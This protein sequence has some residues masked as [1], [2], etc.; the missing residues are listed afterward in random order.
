MRHNSFTVS[1]RRAPLKFS[2][3]RPMPK[4]AAIDPCETHGWWTMAGG[5]DCCLPGSYQG[6]PRAQ[7]H[8]DR[9]NDRGH[10]RRR[11]RRALPMVGDRGGA[12]RSILAVH[13]IR[14]YTLPGR[15]APPG[16]SRSRTPAARPPPPSRGLRRDLSRRSPTRREIPDPP[17][18]TRARS[19]SAGPTVVP[20]VKVARQ[21]DPRSA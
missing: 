21:I 20:L 10:W 11:H 1:R 16:P 3:S 13:L 19:G 14:S 9:R 6:K 2:G 7:P 15:M 17:G 8:R 12:V 5:S 18:P 4:A